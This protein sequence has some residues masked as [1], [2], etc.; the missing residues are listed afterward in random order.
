MKLKNLLPVDADSDA[1]F[2]A[3][4]VK[5]VSADSRITK[6]GHLFVAM[7]GA[8]DDGLR[9]VGQAL[10]AGAVAVMAERVAAMPL[11]EGV[12]FIKVGNAR[13]ALSLAAA[14][15]YSRQ[16][17]VIAAVTGTSGKTSVAA[18]TRQI[19]AALGE[20]S[21]SIGTVGLVS[22]TPQGYASPT[23]PDP[24]PPPPPPS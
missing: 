4:A 10:A 7:A 16:P 12:A 3:L 23:P 6:P 21:A 17:E 2:D 9:F 8:K 18:F 13:R 5:G 22:P 15:L 11:P 1:R 20:T 19:W 14:K 24:R